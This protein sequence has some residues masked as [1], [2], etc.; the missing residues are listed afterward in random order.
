MDSQDTRMQISRK[1]MRRLLITDQKGK[2][3]RYYKKN[4]KDDT[5]GVMRKQM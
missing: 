5:M 3:R 2:S 4:K 1:R